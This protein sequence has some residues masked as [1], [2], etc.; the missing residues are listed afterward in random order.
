MENQQAKKLPL[1]EVAVVLVVTFSLTI[2]AGAIVLLLAGMAATL[3]AGEIFI[4]LVPLAYLIIKRVNVKEYVRISFNPKY[5]AIGIGC[6]VLLLF[7]NI[8]VS[9]TLT[10][11]FGESA[12][13]AESNE[14]LA[15]LATSPAG[16]AA[17]SISLALAG[18]CEEFAFR[19]FLQNTIFRHMKDSKY[20]KYAFVVSALTAATVFGIF[21][22]DPQGVYIFS[23]LISGF[24]LGY[25]YY[26]WNYTVSAT[27]HSTMNI[28]V[29]IFLMLAIN[30]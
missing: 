9:G 23:A 22:F 1:W 11:I 14:L 10:Y 6:G 8:I 28:I 5:L 24:V 4:L 26:R 21:H 20:S 17:V 12:A 15:N 13:V 27:A 16:L 18:V 3:V 2:V 19:G 7:V 25:F 29:L 30:V